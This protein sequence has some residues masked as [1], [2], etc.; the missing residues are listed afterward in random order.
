M[1]YII[2]ILTL[3]NREMPTAHAIR[4]IIIFSNE[5]QAPY[6]K[7]RTLLPFGGPNVHG[8]TIRRQPIQ[9]LIFHPPPQQPQ[10]NLLSLPSSSILPPRHLLLRPRSTVPAASALTLRLHLQRSLPRPPT[11]QPPHQISLDSHS[12]L[13]RFPDPRPM[14]KFEC[15]AIGE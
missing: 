8:P 14:Q 11:P 7:H 15:D 6:T 10:P 3:Q 4:R 13:R 1:L 2:A 9:L 5:L 12:R